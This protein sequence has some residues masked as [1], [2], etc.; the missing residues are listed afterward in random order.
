MNELVRLI[1]PYHKTPLTAVK[2]NHVCLTCGRL[3]S[4]YAH[5]KDD[6]SPQMKFDRL[7]QVVRDLHTL[8]HQPQKYEMKE[9]DY[10]EI[11]QGYVGVANVNASNFLAVRS[12]KGELKCLLSFDDHRLKMLLKRILEYY[13]EREVENGVDFMVNIEW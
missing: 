3:D 9:D 7:L 11:T 5:N 8:L 12:K 13:T 4:G 1:C 6:S 2:D 10:C